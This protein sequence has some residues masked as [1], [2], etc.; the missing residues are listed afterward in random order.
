MKIL[1]IIMRVLLGLVLLLPILGTLGVFPAPTADMYSPS[2]WAFM[3][4]LMNTGY[5]MPLIGSV[6]FAALVCVVLNRT[7]LAAIILL[8]FTV[9]VVLHHIFVDHSFLT[10]SASLAHV[11]WVTNAYFLWLNWPKY[12]TLWQA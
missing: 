4:A 2:G 3:Q 10:A 9:N 12:R 1:T 8:P 11:L 5:I 7:A 6:C